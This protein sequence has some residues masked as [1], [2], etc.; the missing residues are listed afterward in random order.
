MTDPLDVAVRRE[1][2]AHRA[3]SVFRTAAE[4]LE[5]GGYKLPDISSDAIDTNAINRQRSSSGSA[6]QRSTRKKKWNLAIKTTSTTSKL[7]RKGKSNLRQESQRNTKLR[8]K[9][10]VE[11]GTK[12]KMNSELE[13]ENNVCRRQH[14]HKTEPTLSLCVFI[15][16]H[17]RII[18]VCTGIILFLF[19][20]VV[21]VHAQINV[22]DGGDGGGGGNG[23]GDGSGDSKSMCV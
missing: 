13:M 7:K 20:V 9:K 10:R 14:Q 1:C 11:L 8:R 6:R 5:V 16:S 23:D 18:L 21:T 2:G 22:T 4:L 3:Y 17:F 19:F 12:K 15:R